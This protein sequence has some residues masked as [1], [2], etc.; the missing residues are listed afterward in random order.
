MRN[1]AM[2]I[3]YDGT[4][5]HGW[6]YQPNGI[7]VQE[8]VESTLKKVTGDEIKVTGCSRTDA[9]VHA[10]EYFLNFHSE[11][12]IPPERLPFAFNNN[13]ASNAVSAISA[14]YVSDSFNSRFSCKGKRYIY[15]LHNSRV[16]NPFTCRYSW[17]YPY[18]LD[19]EK[20]KE[21][22][23]YFVGSYDFSSFMAAGGSQKTTVRN[24]TECT[25]ER[26]KIWASD[27]VIT[28]E[29]NAFLYNMVRII[30]GTLCDVGTGRLKPSD[31]P[32]IIESRSRSSAGATA[33]PNG[34]H[35]YK[36]YYDTD[37]CKM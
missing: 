8:L 11:T 22:A 5:L 28:V 27:I 15:K 9:G 32:D 13:L 6:Q 29:A 2:K 1:I 21:A 33:P 34:L 35:L 14:C 26:D 18:K 4:D 23:G 20:M 7:T 37:I 24:V 10:V 17:N 12:Q 19:V 36:V 31:I 3:M 25:V 16:L 30:T